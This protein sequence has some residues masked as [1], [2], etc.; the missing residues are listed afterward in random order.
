MCKVVSLVDVRVVEGG[1]EVLSLERWCVGGES[2]VLGMKDV[3]MVLDDVGVDL[4]VR[5]W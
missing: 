3:V 2:G 5:E 4:V 1:G